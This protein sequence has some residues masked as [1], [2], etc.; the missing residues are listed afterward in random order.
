MNSYQQMRLFKARGEIESAKAKGYRVYEKRAGNK[1]V[2]KI[3][4]EELKVDIYID[5]V[6]LADLKSKWQRSG[7]LKYITFYD[8]LLKNELED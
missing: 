6:A 4:C 5:D 2:A 1:T 8:W 7:Y 3:V